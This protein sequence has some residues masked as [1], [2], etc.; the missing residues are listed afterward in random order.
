[1]NDLR[2]DQKAVLDHDVDIVKSLA[3]KGY[4]IDVSWTRR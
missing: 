4:E 3:D 2:P 1:M